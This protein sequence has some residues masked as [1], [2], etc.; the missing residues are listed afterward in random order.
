MYLNDK[1]TSDIL[2]KNPDDV[3]IFN[4]DVL[5]FANELNLA[6]SL[7]QGDAYINKFQE[8]A[9]KLDKVLASNNE[10]DIHELA[11]DIRENTAN[12]KGES[13][14]DN[15]K[16]EDVLKAISESNK[17]HVKWAK[18]L[19]EVKRDIEDLAGTDVSRRGIDEMQLLL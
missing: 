2:D 19:L 3:R 9:D 18:E 12:E 1:L 13:L 6:S 11:K 7:G 8:N 14:Y 17:E 15:M 4:N 10:S 16:D 5:R